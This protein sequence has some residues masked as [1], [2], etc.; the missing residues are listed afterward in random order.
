MDA[1][2]D[3][4]RVLRFSGGV[5]LES[6][7]RAPWCV[8]SQIRPE[9]CGQPAGAEVVMI[10]FHY[11]LD[12]E[13]QFRV[14]KEAAR[15]ALPGQMILVPHN[16]C[17]F[18]GSD[19]SLPALEAR[20]LVR[21]ANDQEM[22]QIDHGSGDRVL[23]H[24]VCGYLTMAAPRHPV[25][26]AL[27]PVLLADVRG[28]SCADWAESSFRYAAREHATR[29]PGSQEILARLSELLFVE[30]V[31]EHIERLPDD[32]T[33]WLAALRDPALAR[34]L[35]ALH[36]QPAHP[37]TT[38]GLAS[39]ACLSRSAFAERFSGKLGMPPMSYLTQWRMLLAS[40]R[41]R[42]SSETIA[43]IASTVGYESESTFSRAFARE[44][45]VAPGA[46]RKCRA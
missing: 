43:Q 23:N 13:M 2:S 3:L 6:R 11:I 5:F 39:Q 41:L 44:M 8:W 7:F 20:P 25:L 27:P 37:W 14:G 31:R 10:G 36:V 4:L 21:K 9:D 32:A 19:V 1:L 28:Q 26:E 29:R 16:E 38:E 42:E 40:R 17:H 24:F 34:A 30:A 15:T 22:A 33:G 46:W 45:G 12:G 35:A 18:L